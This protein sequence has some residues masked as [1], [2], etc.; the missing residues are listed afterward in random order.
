MKTR[1]RQIVPMKNYLINGKQISVDS[2]E[3]I[4]VPNTHEPI[5]SRELFDRVQGF[6]SETKQKAQLIKQ[7]I[8]PF[9]ANMFKGKV[10]CDKCGHYMH[11]HRQNKDGTYWFRCESQWK[12]AK[13]ACTV[14][15]VKESD[16]KTETMTMLNKQAEAILG[17]R[18]ALEQIAVVSDD[19]AAELREI[20]QHMDK[21]GYML[22][23]LYENMVDGIITKDEFVQMKADYEAKLDALSRQADEIRNRKYKAKADAAEYRELADVISTAIGD[24]KLTGEIVDRLIQEIRVYPDKSFDVSFKFQDEFKEVRRV[25]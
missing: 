17:R 15:S 16:L 13:D 22:R 2:S 23:S 25:G 6:L 24:D 19:S 5:I 7:N 8:A 12:Y 20:N 3:W 10:I 1:I 14:V 18:T 11:R 21:N 9:T 4:C